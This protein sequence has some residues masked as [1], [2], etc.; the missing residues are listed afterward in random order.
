MMAYILVFY[1]RDAS[2]RRE[3]ALLFLRQ[4]KSEQLDL[5]FQSRSSG[6]NEQT[7][8]K[9]QADDNNDKVKDAIKVSGYHNQIE[10]E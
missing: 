7:M 8:V 6:S 2:T 5:S 10:R 9:E 4:V 1:F 3:E